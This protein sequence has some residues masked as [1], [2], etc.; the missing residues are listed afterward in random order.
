MPKG[1]FVGLA[2]IDVVYRVDQFPK[3][4]SKTVAASQD[5]YVGGPAT[6]ACITFA[7]LGGKPVLV[8]VVGEHPIAGVIRQELQ[9]FS[10]G[11][12][13]LDARFDQPPPISSVSVNK[14]GERN[15]ISANA[16]RLAAPSAKVDEAALEGC[17]VLMVDGHF[18]E[19]CQSWAKAARAKGIRVVLDGGS[20][21][22]GTGDLLQSVDIAICS[23]DFMPPGCAKEDDV[24]KYLQGRGVGS[25]AITH[26]ENPVRFVSATSSGTVRVPEIDRVD[27]MGAGDIF[28]GAFCYYAAAGQGLVAALAEATNIAAESCRYN[29]T[30]EW[31]KAPVP[32]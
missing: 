8:S 12:V 6:N 21:K 20:W 32:A 7:H 26:G 25:I 5:V 27:T 29:G 10:V 9:Q 30:R 19:A 15:V 24:L 17:S 3:G 18:M 31:M 22:D 4:N 14:S 2:T 11:L 23:A 16:T 28:H 1:V 13:D